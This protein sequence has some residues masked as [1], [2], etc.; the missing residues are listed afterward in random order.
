MDRSHQ[1]VDYETEDTYV[2]TNNHYLG[3]AVVNAVE[4]SSTLK[5]HR[6]QPAAYLHQRLN[7]T[8]SRHLPT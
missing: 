5:G 6:C 2:V 3:K 1:A 7:W 4:I 8:K